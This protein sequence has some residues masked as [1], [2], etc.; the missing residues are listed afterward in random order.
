M[1]FRFHPEALDEYEGAA[2]YY[3]DCEH[4]L[5]LRFID[6]V[7]RTLRLVLQIPYAGDT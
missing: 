2:A 5:D 1:K 7:E 6:C 3:A 4:V